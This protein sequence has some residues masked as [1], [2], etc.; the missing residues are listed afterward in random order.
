MGLFDALKKVV[1]PDRALQAWVSTLIE[2]SAVRD[3]VS[4]ERARWQPGEPL[5]LLLAGYVGTR[6]TG[7]DVRVEEMIRQFRH[8]F[9]DDQLS[10][11]LMT[12]DPALSAGYFR[13]VRQVQL[14]QVY[15]PFLYSECT[16]HH[17]VIACEGSMF[18]SKFAEALTTM[19]AGSLGMA[20]VEGKLSVG[21]GAEAGH[22]T[23]RMREFVRK[24]VAGSLV[25]CRNEP[26]RG[27]LEALG[28][29]TTSGTDTAW[30]FEPAPPE[31]GQQILRDA[32]WDGVKP[33]LAIAPINP[34][35]WPVRPDLGKAAARAVSGEFAVEHYRSIY[36]HHTS[37]EAD[38][39]YDAYLDGLAEAANA[40]AREEDVFIVLVGSEMLDRLSCEALATRLDAPAPVLVSDELDMYQFVSMLRACSM[41]VSSRFHAIVCSMAGLVPS[42]GVTMDE[43]I[44]NL[45]NDR[46]TPEL[47]LEVDDDD[48]GP[49]LL[50]II[51]ILHTEGDRVRDAIG[52]AYPK[53]LHRMG[54][55]GI[56]LLD[57]V[58]RVYPDYERIDRPRTWDAHLPALSPNLQHIME[59]WS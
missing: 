43:R 11:S 53:Q 8:L 17:G 22:M 1:D 9:G 39:K 36:F 29:R 10:L 31:V 24:H 38:A 32:G 23:P 57:E 34:F 6:N 42:A 52:R 28:V 7:A 18:K 3:A 30:T 49:R 33:V 41:L 27:I 25:I 20:N 50:E 15:P 40:F 59:T 48:L 35:W 12:M 54:Q 4:T 46:E 47:F 55:M 56:E 14:P 58:E 45:M 2:A 5:K 37:R 19:M 26:S 21:Y 44:R 16:Q 51:R 13:R